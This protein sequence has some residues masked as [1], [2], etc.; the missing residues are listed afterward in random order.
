MSNNIRT[1]DAISVLPR[2][3]SEKQVAELYGFKLNTLRNWRISKQGPK[4][5]KING[6]M[7]RYR[8]QDIEEYLM[9]C[10]QMTIDSIDV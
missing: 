9:S 7:I 1:S 6:K 10:M 2:L 8:V 5:M 4:F 3:I